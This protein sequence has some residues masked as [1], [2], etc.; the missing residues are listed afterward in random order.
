MP[1]AWRPEITKIEQLIQ[2]EEARILKLREQPSVW[3]PPEEEVAP[4]AQTFF[5]ETTLPQQTQWRPEQETEYPAFYA[6]ISEPVAP[7]TAKPALVEKAEKEEPISI[8][9]WQRG[10][11][12]F[13][14][15]FNWVDENVIKPGLALLGTTAGFAPDVER[16]TGEDFWE[17]KKRAWEGWKAPGF[18]M[19]VP[20][21]DK[22]WRI[23]LKGVMELAPWLLIPGA[24]TVGGGVRAASGLAGILSKAGKV[25]RILGTA[26]EY[27]PWG[28]AE[29]TAGVAIKGGFRAAGKVSE[30]V[31]TAVGEKLYGKY[32]PPPT[33]PAITKFAS[34]VKETVKPTRRKFE[35]ELPGLRTKQLA[36]LEEVQAKYRRG[37]IPLSEL[38]SAQAMAT[39][40]GIRPQFALT[41]EAI[42]TRQAQSIT[43][44]E[45][46]V[47]SGEIS[48]ATGKALITKIKKSP[49]F[50]A[51]SFTA[52]EVKELNDIIISS[53]ESG[54]IKKNS[55]DAFLRLAT[56]SLD[57]LPEPAI[58][59]DWGKIF[60]DDFARTIG[61]L[62]SPQ[63]A[64]MLVD[65]LNLPRSILASADLSATLR[66]GAILTLL[67][68]TQAPKWFAG[69]VKA[70]F[71][72]KLANQIDDGLKAHPLYKNFIADGGYFAPLR[73]A[74]MMKAEE[75]YMSRLAQR[76]PGVR[77][78]ERGFITYL[79]QARMASYEA[80]YATMAAQGAR[81][82]HFKMLT[83]FI[84]QATGRGDL[85]KSLEKYSPIM[86]A[87][88]FSPRLQT[89]TI[90]LPRQIGRMLLSG[91]PYMRKEA[92]KA[93]ATFVGG[94]VGILSL[95]HNTG[96]SKV[97]IDPRSG[98]FGK[99]K[100]GDTRLD[101]WRGY[102]Q[103]ARFAAQLLTGERKSAYGN[104]NKAERGEIAWRFLQSKS[105]PAFGL[106]VDLLRGETY[107]GDPIFNDT[108]GF[109][110]A[111][112]ERV[113]PLALQDVI[114]AMEQSGVNGLWTAAPATL[115]IGVL[116]YVNQYVKVKEKIARELGYKSWDDIDPKTQREIQNRNA[117][118]Q[119]ATIAFDRQVMGTAWGDWRLA[120]NAVEDVFKTNVDMAVAEYKATGNG[121]GF[122]EKVTD[123]FTERRGGYGAREKEERFADIVKRL[124]V[125]D[126]AEALVSLGPEQM[127][128]KIYND[129]LYGDDMYD[130]FGN[131]RFEEAR[132]RKDQLRQQLGDDM[133]NYI[134]DYQEL[135]FETLP[136]EFQE[137]MQ[138][139]ELMRPYWEVRNQVIRLFGQRFADSSR[140]Q[141]LIS[142]RRKTLRLG[143]RELENA[144]QKYYSR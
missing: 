136:A 4:E 8:P 78:S 76:I 86:N 65:A 21:S 131:Y 109:T 15:P 142:K 26:V 7:P 112:R 89:A 81:P 85:P 38:Q 82:E 16:K 141:S 121:Y 144:Y 63:Q 30:K 60:G 140:G 69:Q 20:W 132:L 5:P 37:E 41:P 119:A 62:Q 23:D 39:A 72:D 113:L 103:Y 13:A 84:N 48:E 61:S 11:Q 133:L 110:K 108:T 9:F 79:N 19:N 138:A 137:L 42:A 1:V 94:G 10:L 130:E 95:L 46:R 71:S 66:Q 36:K 91:N 32:V 116:T 51:P 40:G 102:L 33:S 49:A 120:G 18:D 44:V 107:M 124:N 114:D 93:L 52:D 115:G 106:M 126:T 43:D 22:P 123:A 111:A 58:I 53:A 139:R 45:A 34:Y 143:N 74:T 97:E 57:N 87:V 50:T 75:M 64:N 56:G 92:A 25:G 12:V 73:E 134:E 29:K 77:R 104:M 27:S 70:F 105:S 6:P 59:K 31:S 100:I 127:G 68:P 118:L 47:V 125:K 3:T 99:I 17:W 90:Q 54:F 83:G 55:S 88:L 135:K 101:I 117:E 14:A 35:K 28:L 128:I 2:A 122:N 98:D 67:H 80:A 24:G 96:V 129:A